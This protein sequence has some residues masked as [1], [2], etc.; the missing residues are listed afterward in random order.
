MIKNHSKGKIKRVFKLEINPYH[1]RNV[2]FRTLGYDY[3]ACNFTMS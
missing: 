2:F 1:L 3:V